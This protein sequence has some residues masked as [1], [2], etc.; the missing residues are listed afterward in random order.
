MQRVRGRDEA[1]GAGPGDV[2]EQEG[3]LGELPQWGGGPGRIPV[4]DAHGW[5][6]LGRLVVGGL[7]FGVRLSGRKGKRSCWVWQGSKDTQGASQWPM[8]TA[9]GRWEVSCWGSS[10]SVAWGLGEG[11]VLQMAQQGRGLRGIAVPNAH[12]TVWLEGFGE[13]LGHPAGHGVQR[14]GGLPGPEVAPEGSEEAWGGSRWAGL[15]GD[16]D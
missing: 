3:G 12:G 11:V 2:L 9:G 14:Q 15:E 7:I 16:E 6:H 10:L 1:L 5:G 4:P 8:H 13:V